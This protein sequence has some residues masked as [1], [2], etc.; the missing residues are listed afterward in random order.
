VGK[1][2]PNAGASSFQPP[3]LDVGQRY[4]EPFPPSA[5]ASR[6]VRLPGS[7][8]TRPRESS[9]RSATSPSSAPRQWARR[10]RITVSLTYNAG[11]GRVRK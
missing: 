1:T 8:S 4:Q 11:S 6:G 7:V 5:W 3:R 2:L 9:A 10:Q